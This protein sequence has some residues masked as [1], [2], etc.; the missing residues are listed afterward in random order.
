[1]TAFNWSN[2]QICGRARELLRR[3]DLPRLWSSTA[4]SVLEEGEQRHLANR[5]NSSEQRKSEIVPEVDS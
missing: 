2:I 4:I 1:M 5:R 3:V